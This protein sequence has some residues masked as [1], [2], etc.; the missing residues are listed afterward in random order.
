MKRFY[1]AKKKD[2]HLVPK[3]YLKSFLAQVSNQE[4]EAGI[5]V[6]S[7]NLD[8]SWRMRG[9]KHKTFTK[10]RYYNLFDDD[11]N[12]PR[13][14]DFLS[15]IE[16]SYPKHLRK[17]ELG[18]I[19][20]LTLSFIS[21]FASFQMVR[22]PNFVDR[23]QQIIDSF[24]EFYQKM[25]EEC[26]TV[27]EI[28][29]RSIVDNDFGE[30]LLEHAHVIYNNTD[31]PFIASD[32][33]VISKKV[34][35]EDLRLI[36]PSKYI[37]SDEPLSHESL[38]FIF[39][40]TPSVA[41]ISCDLIEYSQ[42]RKLYLSCVNEVNNINIMTCLNAQ[43]NVFSSTTNLLLDGRYISS[44]INNIYRGEYI[45]LYTHSERLRLP[46]LYEGNVSRELVFRCER[47]LD[48][49]TLELGQEIICLK[50]CIDGK[51][52]R[53]TRYLKITQINKN[54]GLLSF[55]TNLKLS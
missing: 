28:A 24:A 21:N 48:F 51:L 31:V 30:V 1:M 20:E 11:P 17:I 3:C 26:I 36:L 29:K 32:N 15:I 35:V 10:T 50:R 23:A 39:P 53:Q 52:L 34:N 47:T 4:I 45:E 40:L 14:E 8:S 44:L 49:L 16:S 41:Y 19:D 7:K 2:Q 12:N 33:P 5:Y 46:C 54:N 13:I 18:I 37:T 43:K 9:L 38:M 55:G 25:T 6:N 42:N 22:V 27:D